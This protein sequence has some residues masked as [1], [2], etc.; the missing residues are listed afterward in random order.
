VA[1]DRRNLTRLGGSKG[2]VFQMNMNQLSR[3]AIQASVLLWCLFGTG[4]TWSRPTTPG[5]AELVV[6]GWLTRNPE[7]LGAMLGRSVSAVDTIVDDVGA[8]IYYVVR[9][10]PS[11][12]AIVPAD[13]RIEPILA[14]VEGQTYDPAGGDPLSALVQR[15]LVG[16]LARVRAESTASGTLNAQSASEPQLRWDALVGQAGTAVRQL[17]IQGQAPVSDVRVAPLIG[18]RWAQGNVCGGHCYNYY[19]PDHLVCGCVATALA[20]VLHYHRHPA[21]GIGR[22]EFGIE[23]E[24]IAR[25]A[26]T[27]GGDGNGG[28][29]LWEKMPLDP[30]CDIKAEQRRA[31]GALCY[32][33]GVAVGMNYSRTGSGAD[34]LEIGDALTTVF[35]YANAVKGLNNGDNITSGLSAMINPNLDAGHP[36]ILGISGQS[37]HAIVADGYGYDDAPVKTLYHHL[38]MGWAGYGDAW[39]DLPDIRDYNA[40]DVCTYNIFVSERGEIISGRATDPLGRPLAGVVVSVVQRSG[41]YEATTNAKGIYA[42]RGLPSNATLK[43]L[44]GKPHMTFSEQTVRTGQSLSG[45]ALAGTDGVSISPQR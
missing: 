28:P 32:D 29:Y 21:E 41:T 31:I 16:R 39:Y 4:T 34:A 42:L 38:N 14:F 10:A 27:R 25:T 2:I 20:Q 43:V 30:G 19:T 3:L 6:S 33:A 5:E 36:V 15:D 40:V 1:C 9:L 44:A 7:P 22:R 37:G 8:P 35:G 23:V 17:S 24:D 13:D 18:T 26:W 11:G 12:L 45:P